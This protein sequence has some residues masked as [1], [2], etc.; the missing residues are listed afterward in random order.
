MRAGANN[1]NG[2]A[3]CILDDDPSVLKSTGRLLSSAGWPVQPFADPQ[4]FLN[5]ARLHRPRL[6]VIDMA[7]PLMHGLEVQK[8]LGDISPATRVI[9]LTAN[10]D[11]AVRSKAMAAGALAFFVKP[12]EDEKFLSEV[13]SAIKVEPPL[14]RAI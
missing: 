11:P 4:S 10:D 14:R 8:R 5:Y 6:A 12:V 7:M 3:I 13:E 2:S 9:V 1:L